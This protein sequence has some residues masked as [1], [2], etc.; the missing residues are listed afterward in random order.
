MA[1]FK[2]SPY[3]SIH[4]DRKMIVFDKNGNYET[5]NKNELKAIAG[6]QGV[7]EMKKTISN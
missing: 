1:T 3:K 2:S 4:C 5:S 6:A 7:E